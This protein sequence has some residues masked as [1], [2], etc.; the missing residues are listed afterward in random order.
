MC[1]ATDGV[2]HR[3]TT[4]YHKDGTRGSRWVGWSLKSVVKVAGRWTAAPEMSETWSDGRCVS[5]HSNILDIRCD[6]D[7]V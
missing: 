1:S 6:T 5:E 2:N 3:L 4:A 7:F